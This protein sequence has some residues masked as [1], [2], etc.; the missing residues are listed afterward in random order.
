MASL[1]FNTILYIKIIENYES[2]LS[3]SISNIEQSAQLRKIFQK[4]N[5]QDFDNIVRILSD[6][7]DDGMDLDNLFTEKRYLFVKH[8]LLNLGV[9]LKLVFKACSSLLN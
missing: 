2:R 4:L 1:S 6:L 7:Q 3:D 9:S 8:I 5:N